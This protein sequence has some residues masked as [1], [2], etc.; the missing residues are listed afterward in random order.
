MKNIAVLT[1]GGDAPGMNAAIR[2]AVRCGIDAGFDMYGIR[3][4]YRGLLEGDIIEMKRGDVGDILH[5]GGTILKTARCEEFMTAEGIDAAVTR[6][7]DCEIDAVICIGGDGTMK[8]A[9]DLHKNGI[10]VMCLP[11]TID[12]DVAYTDRTIGFDTAVNTCLDAISRIRDTSSSHERTAVIEVMGRHCGDIAIHAGLAGGAEFVL[13][14]EV[15]SELSEVCSKIRSGAA[16]GKL[17]SIIINAE[18]SGYST[19]EVVKYIEEN[20]GRETRPV[21][22]SYLQRGGTPTAEDRMLATL[23]AGKAIE[24]LAEGK[25]GKAVGTVNGNIVAVDIEAAVSMKR[26]NTDNLLMKYVDILSK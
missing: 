13:I 2:A 20:T 9:Y 24:L 18:G 3:Y 17:Q 21:N 14:P 11:G 8:G 6:L 23:T 7:C 25:T 1:S 12:N 16:R 22:L 26:K 10:G 4:G 5:R 19:D 15:K